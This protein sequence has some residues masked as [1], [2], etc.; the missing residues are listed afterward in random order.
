MNILRT[1]VHLVT[2]IYSTSHE[3]GKANGQT[4][5]LAEASPTDVWRNIKMHIIGIYGR[6]KHVE[7]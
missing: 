5:V 1:S 7:M 2:S 3:G 4:I 6:I